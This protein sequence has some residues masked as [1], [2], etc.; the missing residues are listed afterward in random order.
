MY[1][2]IETNGSSSQYIIAE[3]IRDYLESNFGYTIDYSVGLESSPI[4][5]YNS[6][7]DLVASFD[8]KPEE[9]VLDFYFSIVDED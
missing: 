7:N 6:N 8:K 4:S 5:V 2:T 9:S 3:Y 1:F